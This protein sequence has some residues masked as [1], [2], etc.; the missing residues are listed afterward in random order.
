VP[1]F[2]R[3]KYTAPAGPKELVNKRVMLESTPHPVVQN[4]NVAKVAVEHVL[5]LNRA[6]AEADNNNDMF[7]F[8]DLT[9]LEAQ[10]QSLKTKGFLRSYKPYQPPPDL[11]PRFL[12]TCSAALGATVTEDSLASVTLDS[13]ETKAMVLQALHQEFDHLVHS[14]RLH[15]MT[16]L[17]RVFLFYQSEVC[18]L[19]PYEQLHRDKEA[20]KLPANLVIQ[21]DPIRFTGTGDHPLN[22][23]TAWPRSDTLVTG[24]RARERYLTRPAAHTAWEEGDYK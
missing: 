11:G 10:M 20:D 13:L 12:A 21:L 23:V 9:T 19:N 17:D 14:S 22:T 5:S 16:S 7:T 24:L 1:R 15:E 3:S 6:Q 8:G 2:G 4:V 18:V